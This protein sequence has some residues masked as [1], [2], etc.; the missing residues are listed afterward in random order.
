M[1]LERPRT[2]LSSAWEPKPTPRSLR[3]G[4][5]LDV[6]RPADWPMWLW[7]ALFVTAGAASAVVYTIMGLS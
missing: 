1:R 5:V 7:W 2:G 6:E 3:P 4:V